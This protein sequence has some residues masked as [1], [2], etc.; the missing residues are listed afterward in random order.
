MTSFERIKAYVYEQPATHRFSKDYMFNMADMEC[1]TI[2]LRSQDA[3][4][5][6]LV[7]PIRYSYTLTTLLYLS[8]TQMRPR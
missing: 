3:A 5:R 6:L 8:A 4:P 2:N 1:F 7:C